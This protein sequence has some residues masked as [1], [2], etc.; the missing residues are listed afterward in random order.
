MPGSVIDIDS[1]IWENLPLM[2][3]YLDPKYRDLALSIEV[4]ER[5]LEYMSVEGRRPHNLFLREGRFGRMAAGKSIEEKRDLYLK[6][7]AVTYA[8]GPGQRSRL[9][10][11]RPPSPSPGSGRYR[12]LFH[13]PDPRPP[14]GNRR[15]RP[16]SRCRLRPCLQRIRLRLL[17]RLPRPPQAHRP[18]HPPGHRGRHR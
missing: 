10:P 15:S 8:A 7:G 17:Q 14:L 1:H 16:Q 3:E 11:A 13:L 12:H 2:A 9:P 5:G 6:P 4:D 18:H